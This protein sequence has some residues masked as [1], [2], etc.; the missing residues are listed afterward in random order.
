MGKKQ[1]YIQT[2]GRRKSAV[3][4][5]R[6][7]KGKGESTVNGEPVDVYFPGQVMKDIWM[8]PFKLADVGDKYYVS[9]KVEG[10]GKKGQLDAAVHA[11]ARALVKENPDYKKSIKSAGLLGRDARIR[12]RRMVGMGGKSRRK[13]QS[14]KR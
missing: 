8:R 3:A 6:L 10:G 13:K 1:N 2:V 7:F 11:I 9:V 4:R 12:Q 5:G 14:P